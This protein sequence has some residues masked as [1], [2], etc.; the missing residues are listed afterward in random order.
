MGLLEKAG[1]IKD[2]EKPKK[3]T[4]AKT[5]APKPVKTAKAKPVAKE[6]SKREPRKKSP[7]EPR[8][9][10][11][12][13]QLAGRAARGARSLVDFIVSYAGI[14]GL[15]AFT[16]RGSFFNATFNK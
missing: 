4:K 16:A 1:K 11:E 8:V 7:R 12:E 10:P 13:F 3:A 14:V 9:M 6:K 15:I 2:D 5:A